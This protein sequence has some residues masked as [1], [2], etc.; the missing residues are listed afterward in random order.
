M[1]LLLNEDCHL[2]VDDVFRSGQLPAQTVFGDIVS[3]MHRTV[4]N[5]LR[6]FSVEPTQPSTSSTSVSPA[7]A[8]TPVPIVS[9]SG[10]SPSS[11]PTRCVRD[12]CDAII[13]NSFRQTDESLLQSWPTSGPGDYL[14]ELSRNST[15]E[16]PQPK[17]PYR[18]SDVPLD[19]SDGSSISLTSSR[20]D[21]GSS[22]KWSDSVRE[23]RKSVDDGTEASKSSKSD[24][25]VASDECLEQECLEQG[26]TASDSENQAS[27][28]DDQPPLCIDLNRETSDEEDEASSSHDV[29]E[30]GVP[31]DHDEKVLCGSTDK[32]DVVAESQR[33]LIETTVVSEMREKPFRKRKL[34]SD[35]QSSSEV[36]SSE[37]KQK[38]TD[39]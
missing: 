5:S 15:P 9:P 6:G 10:S 35:W 11:K 22:Q 24:V 36:Q 12:V 7:I 31:A 14:S 26:E 33:L 21:T 34:E 38:K 27:D 32:V 30:L 23:T 29:D 39:G 3:L 13:A 1:Y 16:M 18:V 2:S 17:S 19:R 8:T 25:I 4:E 28:I 20:S 37:L